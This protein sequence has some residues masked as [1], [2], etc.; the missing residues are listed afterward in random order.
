MVNMLVGNQ[1]R[2]QPLRV[3]SGKRHAA[4]QLPARQP[5]IH[6]DPRPRTGNYSCIAFRAGSE[7]GHSHLVNIRDLFATATPP[8]TCGR[9]IKWFNPGVLLEAA[10]LTSVT[11][12]S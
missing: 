1:D 5:C 10:T 6:Q 2:V 3:F 7:H 12:G 11:D 9:W 8:K 4:Q